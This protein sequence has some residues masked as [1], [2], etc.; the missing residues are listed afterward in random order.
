MTKLNAAFFKKWCMCLCAASLLGALVSCSD[1]D[2]ATG[3]E[4]TLNVTALPSGTVSA[5]A[6]P[7]VASYS[8]SPGQTGTAWVEF[9]TDTNYGLRTSS[10]ATV[11]GAATILV[12]GMRQNTLY[13]M[14]AKVQLASGEI[15]Q[16]VDHT[17][18]TGAFPT[19]LALP[20]LSVPTNDSPQSGVELVAADLAP[21]NNYL[22]AYAVDLQGNIIWGYTYPGQ[23]AAVVQ[24]IKLLSNGHMMLIAAFASQSVSGPTTSTALVTL[25]EID[26]AGNTIRELTLST[27]NSKLAA[28]GYNL[29]LTDFHHDFVPL[30][31]GHVLLIT[32]T[33]KEIDNVSGYPGANQV[34]GDVIVDLDPNF[35]PVWIWNEFDHLDVNRHPVNFPDW[36]HTNAVLYSK[37]DGNILVSMRHQ[38]WIV[39]V[40]YQ[41]GAGTGNI[42]WR[43]GEGGDFTLTG[44]VDPTDWFYGQ[45]QPSFLSANTTG[46]V[47]MTMMDNG[48][49]R[50]FPA[51]VT[52][53]A[54]GAPAC[55]YTRVPVF[56]IDESAKTAALL[57]QNT[58]PLLQYSYWGGGTTALENGNIE[59]DLCAVPGPMS[60]VREISATANPTVAWELDI[61]GQN[62][63]RANRIPSLYPGIQW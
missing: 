9:G 51:G 52:C 60:I 34:L 56:Q 46:V 6:N 31:N 58:Q 40:D 48:F 8:T 30:P 12:A 32:Q 35:N 37:D 61:T 26:L 18:T 55:D 19:T 17:F 57:Y 24:P 53:D 5:T 39:K 27:L 22:Q 14:R 33:V 10:Q 3:D 20:T 63:Y 23:T 11:K 49:G 15:L 38:S 7:L 28:A 62:A 45:H 29:T 44:G 41:D 59:Y 4:F 2:L 13:H 43:L 54:A 50:L 21:T 42:L 1:S 36:T 16:D 47:T 25:R